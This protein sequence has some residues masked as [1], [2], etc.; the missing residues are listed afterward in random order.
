MESRLSRRVVRL[1]RF[2]GFFPHI[3]A[4][5]PAEVVAGRTGLRIASRYRKDREDLAV[6]DTE[7]GKELATYGYGHLL[8]L[9][10]FVF[11]TDGH[12]LAF[13]SGS[14][15]IRLWHLDPPRDPVTSKGH[16]GKETW[17]LAFSPDGSTLAS[18]GDDGAARFWDSRSGE[19][20][21]VLF[22]LPSLVTSIA[23]SPTDGSI[24]ASGGFD[25]NVRLWDTTTGACLATLSGHQ[26][27]VFAVAFSVDGHTLA[28]TGDD[29]T[30]RLWDVPTGTLRRDPLI[31]RFGCVHALAFHP[32]GRILASEAWT[33]RSGCGTSRLGA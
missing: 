3:S 19:A 10:P 24:L 23:Y 21:K 12:A 22:G 29:H 31:G 5:N 13:G 4:I 25:R 2:L 26:S 33:A 20:G 16:A 9:G 8:G 28:S 17:S 15:L 32:A 14:G 30:V 7:T 1:D 11:S 18:S 6:I 27:K